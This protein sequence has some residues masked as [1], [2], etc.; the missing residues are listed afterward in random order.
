ML[1]IHLDS[2]TPLAEQIRLGLRRAIA[3]EEVKPGDALPT[4]R[5]LANDLGINFNTV[6]RAYRD[7]QR[8]GL[9]AT[10]RGLGTVVL[11]A[12]ESTR[13]SDPA[14]EARFANG[15]ADLLADA[16]LAGMS[17][18]KAAALFKSTMHTFWTEKETEG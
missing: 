15:V 14:V 10:V 16:R 4:V 18:A 3:S 7:L 1:T 9:V 11:A 6:A 17:R 12:E 8:E 5:Q 2:P 13:I